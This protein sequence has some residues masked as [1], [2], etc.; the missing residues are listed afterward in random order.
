MSQIDF[1]VTPGDGVDLEALGDELRTELGKWRATSEEIEDFDVAEQSGDHYRSAVADM[2]P[3]VAV[4]LVVLQGTAQATDSLKTII[5]NVEAI[6]RRIG[7]KPKVS[8][9]VGGKQVEIGDLSDAQREALREALNVD[10]GVDERW[11]G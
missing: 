8:V 4:A 5:D 11:G 6:V 7:G 9:D 3:H 10:D 2:I 1:I